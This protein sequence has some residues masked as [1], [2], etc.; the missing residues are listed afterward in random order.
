MTK[1]RATL[2]T[3]GAFFLL[4]SKPFQSHHSPFILTDKSPVD[5]PHGVPQGAPQAGH[6]GEGGEANGVVL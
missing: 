3:V 5:C 6:D 1:S 2:K 4:Y